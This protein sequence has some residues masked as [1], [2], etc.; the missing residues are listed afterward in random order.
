MS[1]IPEFYDAVKEGDLENVR[2]LNRNNYFKLSVMEEALKLAAFYDYVDIVEYLVSL[3]CYCKIALGEAF[4]R[5]I[6][7]GNLK[8]IK[9]FVNLGFDPRQCKKKFVVMCVYFA[10]NSEIEYLTSLGCDFTKEKLH[11][12]HPDNQLGKNHTVLNKYLVTKINCLDKLGWD[13]VK[14]IPKSIIRCSDSYCCHI[15]KHQYLAASISRKDQY[16]ILKMR[17]CITMLEIVQHRKNLK[18]NLHRNFV[19]KFILKPASMHTQLI[20]IE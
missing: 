1:K 4:D 2:V 19:L 13:F 8:V 17:T 5:S 18:N 3:T 9:F 15:L 12:P 14:E 16:S 10:E 7:F 11:R 20:L 6:S